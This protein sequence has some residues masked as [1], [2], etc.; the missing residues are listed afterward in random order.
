VQP[1]KLL[2]VNAFA[3]FPIGI[4]DELMQSCLWDDA[5]AGFIHKGPN[6]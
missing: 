1:S 6:S 2:C 3:R 4:P 5:Q